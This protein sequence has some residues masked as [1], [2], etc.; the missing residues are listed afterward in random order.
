MARLLKRFKRKRGLPPGSPVEN[1]LQKIEPQI[2]HIR[3]ETENYTEKKIS[4]VQQIELPK[5]GVNWL[6]VNG[7]ANVNTIRQITDLFQL[8][9]LI[10]EDI[11]NA[12]QRSRLEEMNNGLATFLKHF[13]YNDKKLQIE[14]E[15]IAIIL[16]DNNVICFQDGDR[17][18]FN[19]LK[20]RIIDGKGRIRKAEADYLF[21]ALLDI[22]VDDCFIVLEK[23]DDTM[24]E[25]EYE[26]ISEPQQKT[27]QKIYQ[28]KREIIFLRRSI[29]PLRE[30]VAALLRFEDNVV[31]QTTHIYFRDLY[32]HTIQVIDIVETFRDM[33]SSMLDMYLTSVSNKMNEVMKV[34]TIF[35]AIFIPLTF[36][37]GVYGM[38]FNF[39]PE[40]NWK[41][42]YPA[43][44]II[45]LIIGGIMMIYF[46]KKKWF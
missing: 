38:N 31:K 44:W 42:A 37:A 35:A 23:L 11:M 6:Q 10:V 28:M 39:L 25:L 2:T 46:K 4:N 17:D 3:Y 41:W 27:L 19:V 16:I 34:L 21:Y 29:W 8:H 1:G 14:F 15:Q 9:P 43:W 13:H 7:L 45:V 40:L 30:L 5:N 26:L 24:E 20:Q 22:V 33:V 18:I 36:L 32:D 12:E